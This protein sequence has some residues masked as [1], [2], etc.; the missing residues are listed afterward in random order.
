MTAMSDEATAKKGV[1]KQ[2]ARQGGAMHIKDLH[3]F[4]TLRF[5]RGHREFSELM[6][7]LV[8]E[9]L[10]TYDAGSFALTDAGKKATGSML[11]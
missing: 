1:L 2:L 8:A 11:L 9:E 10:V 5:G 4:S 6:E 3:E 7:A